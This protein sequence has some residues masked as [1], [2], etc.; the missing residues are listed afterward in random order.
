MS[1][2]FEIGPNGETMNELAYELCNLLPNDPEFKF[3]QRVHDTEIRLGVSNVRAIIAR[4]K[5]WEEQAAANSGAPKCDC[6]VV[7]HRQA[8]KAKL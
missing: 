7:I 6:P 3:G 4:L 1:G 2:D 8:C 5:F